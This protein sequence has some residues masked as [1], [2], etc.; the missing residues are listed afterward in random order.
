MVIFSLMASRLVGTIALV[1]I[2]GQGGMTCAA[3]EQ[4]IP[5]FPHWIYLILV[6]LLVSRWRSHSGKYFFPWHVTCETI[7]NIHCNCW[8]CI[9][10]MSNRYGWYLLHISQRGDVRPNAVYRNWSRAFH[11]TCLSLLPGPISYRT[12]QSG[13][14]CLWQAMYLLQQTLI[15]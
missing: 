9:C 13:Y 1:T 14:T 11:T 6:L 15:V 12:P 8:R 2:V 4:P 5:T 3:C 7:F 10:H